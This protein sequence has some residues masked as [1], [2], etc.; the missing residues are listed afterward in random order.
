[1]LS[2]IDKKT[3][4]YLIYN[5]NHNYDLFVHLKEIL[6]QNAVLKNSLEFYSLPYKERI[7]AEFQG[8]REIIRLYKEKILNF[9]H[10]KYLSSFLQYAHPFEV[11]FG[12]FRNII[13]YFGSEKQTEQLLPQ[14]DDL[15]LLGSVLLSEFNLFNNQ[16][17]H[18][19]VVLF[20]IKNS[21]ISRIFRTSQPKPSL[22]PKR[23]PLSC[24]PMTQI[25]SFVTIF[26]IT[27]PM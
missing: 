21:P 16:R 7:Q 14:V 17:V 2:P 3:L 12:L 11:H 22:T 1:M 27:Q 15:K 9:D 13:E 26:H 20:N 25:R 4:T 18:D 6:Q 24:L 23:K 8:I 10:I 5:G 19:I